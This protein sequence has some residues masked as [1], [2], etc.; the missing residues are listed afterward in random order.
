MAIDKLAGRTGNVTVPLPGVGVLFTSRLRDVANRVPTGSAEVWLPSSF[1]SRFSGVGAD[2]H[3]V[4]SVV[5][6]DSNQAEKLGGLAAVALDLSEASTGE[7]VVVADLPEPVEIKLPVIFNSTGVSCAYWD[8][9]LSR[10]S[11]AG[12]RISGKSI[13]GGPLY[14]ETRHFS[15]FGAIASGMIATILCANFDLLTLENIQELAGGD[16]HQSFGATVL[17]TFLAGLLLLFVSAAFLDCHRQKQYRWTDEFFLVPAPACASRDPERDGDAGVNDA[18]EEKAPAAAVGLGCPAACLA[19]SESGACRDALDDICSSWFEYFGE[20]RELL[21]S[22]FS[23]CGELCTG[24]NSMT[25]AGVASVVSDRLVKRLLMASSRRS[26]ASSLGLS[27][28]LVAFVLE[29]EDLASFIVDGN[30]ERR[31][32]ASEIQDKH[33]TA[34]FAAASSSREAT[35]TASSSLSAAQGEAGIPH[36]QEEPKVTWPGNGKASGLWRLTPDQ[37]EAWSTLRVEVCEALLHHTGRKQAKHRTLLGMCNTLVHLNPI[38]EIFS[39]DI[40]RTCKQKAALF[41]ADLLGGMVLVA[42]FFQGAGMVAKKKKVAADVCEGGD[43]ESVG[44]RIGRFLVIATASLLI[45]ALPVS[46]LE[47][48]TNKD[49]KKIKGER[50]SKVWQKQLRS[51]RA[52]LHL[53][54]TVTTLFNAF[55]LFYLLVFVA[56][57]DPDDH[58]DFMVAGSVGLLEDVLAFPLVLAISIPAMAGMYLYVHSCAHKVPEEHIVRRARE[59][60][61]NETNIMLPIDAV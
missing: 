33:I 24:H 28:E 60:L 34:S 52:Q 43:E 54:W 55:C 25:L 10:W 37:L 17:F 26:T 21:E 61:H 27:P 59:A 57:I 8:E 15:I 13:E 11:T 14:C 7:N 20:A 29:S 39:I 32:A 36:S 30:M 42:V 23:G 6:V 50:G 56:N 31:K 40:F 18:G 5:D 49:F 48:F 12:V 38:G 46:L 1:L 16:W 4:L 22:L 2:D 51:W 19:C 44:E 47:S 45:A 35:P 58:P 9:K 53:F 3:V 41:S